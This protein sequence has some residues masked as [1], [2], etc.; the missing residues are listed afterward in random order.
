[1]I[2]SGT[3]IQDNRIFNGSTTQEG[4]I[5]SDTVVTQFEGDSGPPAGITVDSILYRADSTLITADNG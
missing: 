2:L 4:N 1:M 5:F 3:T